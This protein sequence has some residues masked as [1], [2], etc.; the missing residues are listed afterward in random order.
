[1]L[2]I[3]LFGPPGCGKGTQS[4]M[5]VEKYGLTYISTGDLLRKEIAANTELGIKAK[6][7]IDKG[8]LVGDDLVVKL[9]EKHVEN[10]HAQGI[11][12]DGFPRTHVQCYILDGILADMKSSLTV[13]IN[14]EVPENI[15]MQRM[16]E[17]SK[18]SGRS[19]DNETVIKMRF[20]EYQEKTLPVVE[21]YQRQNKVHTIN[22]VGTVE[23]IAQRIQNVIE[24]I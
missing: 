22:G 19:D 10:N 9:I 16:L 20:K 2:N 14:L 21:F 24:S 12:F 8:G 7:I 13:M 23:E 1:M 6:I 4:K 17:R 11:L 3:A 18:I 5:L 15:L